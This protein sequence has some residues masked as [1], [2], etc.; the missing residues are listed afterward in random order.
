[1]TRALGWLSVA[2]LTTTA[3]A[4]VALL[5]KMLGWGILVLVAVA[6]SLNRAMEHLYRHGPPWR[7]P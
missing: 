7:S 3:G 5:A 2:L 1:M 4:M 6:V